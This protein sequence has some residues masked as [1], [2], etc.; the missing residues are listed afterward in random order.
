MNKAVKPTILG[1]GEEFELDLY[2][3]KRPEAYG[4]I[5]FKCPECGNEQSHDLSHGENLEYGEFFGFD[6]CHECGVNFEP[7]YFKVVSTIKIELK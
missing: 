7:Q 4:E 2:N 6:D 3:C 5:T 1:L